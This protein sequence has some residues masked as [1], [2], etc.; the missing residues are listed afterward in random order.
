VKNARYLTLIALGTA[1]I[2][3]ARHERPKAGVLTVLVVFFAVT[4]AFSVQYLMWMVPFAVLNEE[5]RW[6]TR[7]TLAAF[8]YMLLAYTTLILEMHITNLLP[9]PQADW[10]LIMP[11]GLPA[12][13]VTVGW[14]KER[15]VRGDGEGWEWT[16]VF[17]FG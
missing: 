17:T 3:R 10:F 14:A 12:W 13:L 5:H 11:A 7:Y 16:D 2:L 9:W 15:L 6:L 4:H 8:A 1:W